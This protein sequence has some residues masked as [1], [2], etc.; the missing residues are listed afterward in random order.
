MKKL[1]ITL[2]I[3]LLIVN[4]VG[5]TKKEVTVPLNTDNVNKES[6]KNVVESK[7]ET[8]KDVQNEEQK[9]NVSYNLLDTV[10]ENTDKNIIIHYPKM[11]GFKGELLQ[12]YINQS[13]SNITNIYG[14]SE[15]Y[16][17]LKIA[18][19][20]TKQDNDILSVVFRGKG[21]FQ[22]QKEFNILKSV[23]IDMKNSTNEINYDNL[24]KDDKQMRQILSK[25]I[26]EKDSSDYFEA[27]KINIYYKNNQIVFFYMPLDDSAIDFIE[28]PVESKEIKGILNDNFGE[29]PAS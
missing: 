23:N 24:I 4:L 5:C 11:T 10:F 8:S 6:T 13:L 2:L 3:G 22:K 18:Y 25:K 20:V 17:D 15:Y 1:L 26:S 16:T 19:E 12:D 9:N 7:V 27:E 21:K 14:N 29:K 28:I